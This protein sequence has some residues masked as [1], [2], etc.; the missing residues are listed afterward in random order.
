VLW[1]KFGEFGRGR[2]FFAWARGEVANFARR[3]A[4]P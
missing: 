3:P 4:L 1:N 2:D